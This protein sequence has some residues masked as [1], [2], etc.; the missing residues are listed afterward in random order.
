V[1]LGSLP[2]KWAPRYF[3]DEP[4]SR[5]PDGP[6]STVDTR[7][8]E[9]S[10]RQAGRG[11]QTLLLLHGIGGNANGW[12]RQYEAFSSAFRVVGWDAPGYGKSFNFPT[13]AP[14]LEDYAAAVVALLDAL[15]VERAIVLGHS[16]GGL[17]AACTA[18]TFPQRVSQLILAD[19]SSGHKTYD[20]EA[21]E[22]MLQT[23]LAGLAQGDA[24][25]YAKSRYKNLLSPNPSPA[26]VE[27]CISVLAQL[28][29]QGFSQAARM[30]SDADIFPLLPSITAQAR[31]ICGAQDAVTPEALN[32]KI[33]A[34][35]PRADFVSIAEAG[36]WS[37][38]EKPAEF[39]AAVLG[40]LSV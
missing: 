4:V 25:A 2:V 24:L 5:N 13:E 3:H 21:R 35:M 16:L 36:H 10:F 40:F 31:V 15:K 20:K 23:R 38:L 26:A 7:L 8:G 33:A 14:A 28:K 37:F 17:I 32:R 11:A 22:R 18:A 30:I 29:Q 19:C 9:M 27:E 6:R 39:N 34:A 1:N 12:E